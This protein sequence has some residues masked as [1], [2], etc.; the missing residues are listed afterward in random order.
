M[1]S[2]DVEKQ[3]IAIA[4][5]CSAD[6]MAN[7]EQE[8]ETLIANLPEKE[9]GEYKAEFDWLLATIEYNDDFLTYT[10][11][12]NKLTQ[13]DGLLIKFFR[14]G[15]LDK[16]QVINRDWSSQPEERHENNV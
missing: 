14:N 13:Q 5:K 10:K 2:R 11:R 15:E 9:A 12:G 8:L 6:E 4:D 16:Y 1:F 7:V 3:L